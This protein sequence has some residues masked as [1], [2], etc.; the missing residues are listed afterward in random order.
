MVLSGL[1]STGIRL[2]RPGGGGPVRR[3]QTTGRKRRIVCSGRLCGDAATPI[4]TRMSE[5]Q[6][7]SLGGSLALVTGAS[8]G[9]G[10]AV[11]I[12]L[13]GQGTH[14]VIAGRDDD[15]LART[16]DAIRAAGGEATLLPADLARAD[17]ADAIGANIYERFGRLDILV[18]AAFMRVAPAPTGRIDDEDWSRG[19]AVNA[20]A[21]WRLIRTAEPLLRAARYGRAVVVTDAAT[22]S[23]PAYTAALSAG[24]AAR[25]AVTLAWARETVRTSLRVNLLE[26]PA[27]SASGR[28][29]DAIV[30]L[31]QPAE[32]RHG[33]IVSIS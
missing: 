19:L 1:P 16:D 23:S 26:V 3:P 27:L 25:R 20:T 2:R 21:T 24:M 12:A 28:A 6:H 9:L 22:A 11:A 8:R 5:T 33:E 18:H 14:V 29:V 31:C 32:A 15:G 10:A 13:A 4:L 17:V 7:R 30:A